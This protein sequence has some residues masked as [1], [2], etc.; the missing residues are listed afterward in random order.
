MFANALS[1]EAQ[2][3]RD[4]WIYLA[5]QTL[6]LALLVSVVEVIFKHTA[7]LVGWQKHEV[8]LLTILWVIIEECYTIFFKK[9][10]MD[11][12]NKVTDGQLDMILTQ[13]FLLRGVYR[14]IVQIALLAY[15]IIHF[16]FAASWWH[17]PLTFFFII[18]GVFVH[19]AFSLILNTFS[20]W[21]MRI[22]NVND[23]WSAVNA[24]GKYP[25][26]VL[27]PFIK[28]LTLTAVPIAFISYGQVAT[29]TGRWG[30]QLILY[31]FV[32][33][34]FLVL[35]ARVLEFCR[36]TLFERVE[37]IWFIFIV[38]ESF[39]P[40]GREPCKKSFFMIASKYLSP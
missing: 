8:Y 31:G 39:L 7:S 23:L 2:Y 27:P 13:I 37:L 11:L 36:K 32:F 17:V 29:L 22:D 26:E 18:C 3:R 12:P 30:L 4:T 21:Y 15:L 5:S 10:M 16:D 25:L 1:Y 14:M 28:I 34:F 38:C 35:A 33:T 40:D 24:V 6:W 19:Y 9:N 20:F